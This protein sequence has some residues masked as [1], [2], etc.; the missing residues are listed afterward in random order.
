MSKMCCTNVYHITIFSNYKSVYELFYVAWNFIY[1]D[2]LLLLLLLL[3]VIML[4]LNVSKTSPLMWYF[5]SAIPRD[6]YKRQHTH[7]SDDGD[8]K[9]DCQN[10]I[11]H[12]GKYNL[13]RNK[14]YLLLTVLK[15]A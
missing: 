10:S 6:V 2:F 13:V 11:K 8:S 14:K 15:Q 9:K 3:C 12:I 4:F 7:M 5:Y 1:T